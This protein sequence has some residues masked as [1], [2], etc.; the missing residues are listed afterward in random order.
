MGKSSSTVKKEMEN[1]QRS[2]EEMDGGKEVI[3]AR[4]RKA[5]RETLWLVGFREQG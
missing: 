4:K 3:L 5:E 1:K 2:R